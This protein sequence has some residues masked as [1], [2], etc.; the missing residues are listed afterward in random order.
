[1]RRIER[2]PAMIAK[3]ERT[4]KGRASSPSTKARVAERS[5]KAR[6]AYFF[7]NAVALSE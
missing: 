6:P 3:G 2:V 5:R 1:M 4:P 7:A